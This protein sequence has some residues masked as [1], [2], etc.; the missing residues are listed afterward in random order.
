MPTGGMCRLMPTMNSH[1]KQMPE[2]SLRYTF[3]IIS[4]KA[5]PSHRIDGTH[6][7]VALY[8][9]KGWHDCIAF[10]SKGNLQN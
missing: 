3:Q 5:T 8:S 6:Q 4:S 10:S 9:A 7:E 2:I 1:W